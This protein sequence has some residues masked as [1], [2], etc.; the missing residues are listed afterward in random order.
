MGEVD[1][2]R[3]SFINRIDEYLPKDTTPRMSFK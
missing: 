1:S 3:V 2:Q